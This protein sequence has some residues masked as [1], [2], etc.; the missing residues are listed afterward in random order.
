MLWTFPL[1]EFVVPQGC[2]GLQPPETK[3]RL[4]QLRKYRLAI[5]A[6]ATCY[7]V[8]ALQSRIFHSGKLSKSKPFGIF[9]LRRAGFILSADISS[10]RNKHVCAPKPT[11]C[12]F[13]CRLFADGKAAGRCR[14]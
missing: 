2:D 1:V 8:S 9:V 7:P 5:E 4:A 13:S 14:Q 11:L 10:R 12:G 6:I 3:Q